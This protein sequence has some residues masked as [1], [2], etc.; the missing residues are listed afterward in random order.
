[1]IGSPGAALD[2]IL[3]PCVAALGR[4]P[5]VEFLVE[6]VSP[7]RPGGDGDPGAHRHDQQHSECQRDEDT[8]HLSRPSL[9]SRVD[10]PRVE[11]Q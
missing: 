8:T 11:Q 2:P 6:P 7:L 4:A 10:A 3:A 9:A 1:M 5:W